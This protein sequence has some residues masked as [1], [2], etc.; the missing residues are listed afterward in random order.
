MNPV[1]QI[2]MILVKNVSLGAY[3]TGMFLMTFANRDELRKFFDRHKAFRNI[4]VALGVLGFIVFI[5]DLP[6]VVGWAKRP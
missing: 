1:V 4:Y 2:I 5:T 6:I 3:T